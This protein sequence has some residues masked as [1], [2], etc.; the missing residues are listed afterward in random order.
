MEWEQQRGSCERG[1]GESPEVSLDGGC[2][3]GNDLGDEDARVADDVRVLPAPG[4][5]ET[6]SGITLQHKASVSA[7]PIHQ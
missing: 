5:A 3:S 7:V 4:N 1:S 6:E 2:A